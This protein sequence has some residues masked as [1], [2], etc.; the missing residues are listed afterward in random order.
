MAGRYYLAAYDDALPPP[1]EVRGG[2]FLRKFKYDRREPNARRWKQLVAPHG[3]YE[4]LIIWERMSRDSNKAVPRDDASLNLGNN[5]RQVDVA[6]W[7]WRQA[8]GWRAGDWLARRVFVRIHAPKDEKPATA[9]K[10]SVPTT[11]PAQK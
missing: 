5:W 7:R 3:P 9:R 1:E 8:R 6:Y 11:R 4:K 2:A 10:P